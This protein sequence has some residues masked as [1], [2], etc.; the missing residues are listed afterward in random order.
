MAIFILGNTI[1][2]GTHTLYAGKIIDSAQHNI[3]ALESAGA[4]LIPTNPEAVAAGEA[5]SKSKRRGAFTTPTLAF[6]LASGLSTAG[7]AGNAPAN[8]QVPVWNATTGKFEWTTPLTTDEKVKASPA[9]TT[10]SELLAKIA[11]GSGISLAILNPG[12]NE[13][14]QITGSGGGGGGSGGFGGVSLP[15]WVS[16]L[17]DTFDKT[18][19]VILTTTGAGDL[20]TAVAALN[21]G[22]LLRVDTNATYTPIVIPAGK[23]IGIVAGEGWAPKITG[24]HG[25]GLNNG[26]ADV[27]IAGLILDACTSGA[28]NQQGAGITFAQHQTIVNR[29]AFVNMSITNTSGTASGAM[30]S[31]HWTVG[32][33]NY[34]NANTPA[35]FSDKIAFVGCHTYKAG[36]GGIEQ[37]AITARG[38]SNLYVGGSYFDGGGT[39]CRGVSLQNCTDFVI[40]SCESWNHLTG[41]NCEAFKI[42]EIGTAIGYSNT[43]VIRYCVAHDA[44]EGFDID[45]NCNC[46]VH[47]CL[48]FNITDEAFGLDD[49]SR[50]TFTGCIAYNSGTGFRLEAA[51]V[52]QLSNNNAIA[53]STP[54]RLDNGYVA[55][56][57][58]RIDPKSLPPSWVAPGLVPLGVGIENTALVNPKAWNASDNGDPS[59]PFV[60][61][62]GAIDAF[63][64]PVDAASELRR[65]M[66]LIAAG[67]YNEDL[68]IGPA[69]RTFLI[70]LGPVTLGDGAGTNFGSTTPR[71]ITWNNDQAAEFS[72]ARPTLFIGTINWGGE[73][74]STHTAYASSFDITGGLIMTETPGGTTTELHLQGVKIRGSVDASAA[75]VSIFNCYFYRS[76]F[77]TTVDF[78]NGILNIAESC[79]FDGPT[80]FASY[81]RCTQCEFDGNT[82]FT[83]GVNATLPPTGFYGCDIAGTVTTPGTLE[84]DGVSNFKFKA[85]GAVLAGGGAKSI[86]EDLVP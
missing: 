68:V 10:P 66:I 30:F 20:A 28:P 34:A 65:D 35:E 85:N 14:L 75:P 50:C 83:S 33:D 86:I 27:L 78:P 32:G 67:K 52:A 64:A 58:N 43:G 21:D 8:G 19:D 72:K 38:V 57:S 9:D 63:P 40:E 55:D 29:I 56:A 48:A 22:E 77:D 84:L 79:E 18:P 7:D 54:Y 5:L 80:T 6:M 62:Q 26:A 17:L 25:I 15:D 23:S 46:E 47:D 1:Q 4:V 42:D 24:Q 13:Q 82:N 60:T 70:G 31:Y 39:D 53:C 81:C 73:A 74:S 49:S 41:G 69:R 12:A 16:T 51:S 59:T 44:V 76:F 45:D 71:S 3:A 36:V 11:A 37:A 61:I 2:F